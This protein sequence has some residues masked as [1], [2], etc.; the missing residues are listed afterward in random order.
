M[1]N[2]VFVDL[3][4]F[5][6]ELMLAKRLFNLG[7]RTPVVCS[8]C[9]IKRK[10]ATRLYWFAQKQAPIKGMLPWD[11]HWI[12]RSTLNNL[13]ASIFLGLIQDYVPE[14]CS[15]IEFG[16]QFCDAYALYCRIVSQNPKPCNREAG[17][18]HYRVLDINRAW[19]LTQQFRASTLR[20]VTCLSCHARHLGL[21]QVEQHPIH[22]PVCQTKTGDMN[23]Q[24]RISRTFSQ[25][26]RK[27]S[28]IC[29][30]RF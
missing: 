18:E 15:G 28:A 13:H 9:G 10:T 12:E 17:F 14:H 24:P 25:N 16:Q 27:T 1:N 23:R 4:H 3:S 29:L 8:L 2:G 22:C 7:A 30:G 5:G 21:H 19:Q 20:F 11:P 26:A 6:V